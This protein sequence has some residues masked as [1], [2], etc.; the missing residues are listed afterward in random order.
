M[1]RAGRTDVDVQTQDVGPLSRG[2]VGGSE[3]AR[4]HRSGPRNAR[5]ARNRRGA[6]VRHDRLSASVLAGTALTLRSLWC[7]GAGRCDAASMLLYAKQEQKQARRWLDL[8]GRLDS[9]TT[10]H[11][12]TWDA[13]HEL[14]QQHCEPPVP[15]AAR[16]DVVVQVLASWRAFLGPDTSIGFIESLGYWDITGPDGTAYQNVD[17]SRLR[18][19][20]GWIPQLSDVT[21]MLLSAGERLNPTPEVPL[22]DH[23][24]IDY[25]MDGVEEDTIHY[26]PRPP[27]RMNY[28]RILGA[29]S[30]MKAHD[31]Q[32]G[33]NTSAC[34]P[35]FS[36]G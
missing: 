9:V 18:K 26:G 14:P 7:R 32:T 15:M 23:Y 21:A 31:L 24:Q 35:L 2:R 3:R 27:V 34:K 10:D 12:L 17:P 36:L 4:L 30:I 6:V 8:G 16:I 25:G 29:E 19:L 13:R 20:T 28:G 33:V 11:A 1:A 5:R 22:I